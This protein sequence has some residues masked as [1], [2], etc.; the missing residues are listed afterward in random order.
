MKAQAELR[1]LNVVCPHCAKTNRV[2]EARLTG[3]PQCG[4]CKQ[5]LFEGQP[6]E[7]TGAELERH[8]AADLPV[9]ADFWA[10]WCGPCR[11]MG[12]VFSSV[13]REMEPQA[14]FVKI[15][16]DVDLETASRL[17]IPGIPTLI[18]FK[19]GREVAR[20]A[21]AMDATRLRVWLHANL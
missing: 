1:T 16:T 18:V 10:P 8:I 14:R 13:A 12:P 2:P 20:C 7:L 9:V 5:S 6:A 4:A 11:V 19:H 21:G 3:Q 15:N 17:D